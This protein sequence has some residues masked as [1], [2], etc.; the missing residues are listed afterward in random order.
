MPAPENDP[1]DFDRIDREIRINQMEEELKD[2]SGGQMVSGGASEDCPPEV[3]EKF[4]EHVLKFERGEWTTHVE[5]LKG[6]G[7]ELPPPDE[8]DDAAVTARL[9]EVIRGLE[10][11]HTYLYCTNHLSD[12]E[13]YTHLWKDALREHTVD[14]SSEPGAACH[15]DLLGSGNEEDT[16]LY[17][18]H[19]ADEAWRQDW[20]KSFPDFV[21]PAHQDP[22][23]DRDRH[24]P[25]R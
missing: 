16:R 22:P 13:L 15:L 17:L 20:Q 24:L 10:R 4:L 21:L 9:W 14:M 7:I 3:K 2:L 6:L 1:L 19:Y 23:Y 5:L 18:K 8:L 12:R 11:L 25:R